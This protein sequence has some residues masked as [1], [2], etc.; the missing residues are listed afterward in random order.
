MKQLLY[1]LPLLA[2]PM[3]LTA[4]RQ[5]TPL[6]YDGTTGI[7]FQPVDM[8]RD[9]WSQT[10]YPS[11]TDTNFVREFFFTYDSIASNGK[12]IPDTNASRVYT[13]HVAAQGYTTAFAR[14][15]AVVADSSSTLDKAD[16]EIVTNLNYIDKGKVDGV[17][18][19]RLK[20]PALDDT[21]VEKLVLRLVP[22]DYFAYVNGDGEYFTLLLSNTNRKPRYWD[23]VSNLNSSVSE[24]FGIY[25]QS[26]FNFIHEV[27]YNYQEEDDD[28]NPTFPYRQYASL[29]GF[30]Y[31]GVAT[32]KATEIQDVL[33][34][35]YQTR[36]D[37]GMA[38]IID[39]NTGREIR[40][41]L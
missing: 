8:F 36:K 15:V 37:D 34:M 16:Y 40:F 41:G 2:L 21:K 12:N 19:V 29:E 31:L 27:L 17:V 32:D 30:R 4:C 38:P 22:N 1:F 28:G 14:P 5:D 6:P 39:E 24:N 9:N 20:R 25:S 33:Q 23:A 3:L 18:T 10:T 13:I 26:K 11:E 7:T 35:E